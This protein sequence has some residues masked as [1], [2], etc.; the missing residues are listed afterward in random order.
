MPEEFKR[1]YE[2]TMFILREVDADSKDSP[3]WF[4]EQILTDNHNLIQDDD[5]KRWLLTFEE[6]NIY[7]NEKYF[8]RVWT[9]KANSYAKVLDG[10]D[11][12]LA[13][14]ETT[15]YNTF[16]SNLKQVEC[17][18]RKLP[19]VCSDVV[20]YNVYGVDN[21]NCMLVENKKNSAKHWKKKLKE[22]ILDPEKRRVIGENLYNDFSEKFNLELVTKRRAEFYGKL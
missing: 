18:T 5:Y 19:I 15:K 11:I 3:Y 1:M 12:V 6:N 16:K 17:W 9:Q 14:L 22:L 7:H 8:S 4:Y 13:P 10:I 2:G 21:H 20:P